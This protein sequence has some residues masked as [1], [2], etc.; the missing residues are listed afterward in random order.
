VTAA[1]KKIGACRTGRP[2]KRNALRHLVAAHEL[3]IARRAMAT[4]K[5]D[6]ARRPGGVR[7]VVHA[8]N[9]GGT[10]DVTRGVWR[11]PRDAAPS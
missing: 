8:S 9:R 2:D 1:A 11:W 7:S 4:G 10:S 5:G 3:D 6:G